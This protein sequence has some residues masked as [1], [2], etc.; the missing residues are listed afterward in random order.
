MSGRLAVC[1]LAGL[2]WSHFAGLLSDFH[3]GRASGLVDLSRHA[4][5]AENHTPLAPGCARPAETRPILKSVES[6]LLAPAAQIKDLQA[7]DSE[8]K[9]QG[10]H[11]LQALIDTGSQLSSLDLDLAKALGVDR[12]VI[13]YRR[14]RNVHGSTRRPVIRLSFRIGG[15]WR[16][17][18][19]TLI[20]RQQMR[21]RVLIGREALDG[22]LIDPR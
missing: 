12:Q 22:F 19:F 9:K 10:A 17:A 2:L 16:N 20:S 11:E 5:L 15:Q 7:S 8:L 1:V 4:A 3:L 13:G 6:I 14:V 21:Y 18:K